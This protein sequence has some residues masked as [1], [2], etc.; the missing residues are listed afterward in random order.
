ME[1]EVGTNAFAAQRPTRGFFA[2]GLL[3]AFLVAAILFG[4]IGWIFT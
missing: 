1:N 4:T 2:R 3:V